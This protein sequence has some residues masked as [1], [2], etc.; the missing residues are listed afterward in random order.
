MIF[1]MHPTYR[2]IHATSF[3]PSVVE[4]RLEHE[5]AK[6]VPLHVNFSNTSFNDELISTIVTL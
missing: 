2:R 1:Y 4:Q 6:W 3:V 5:I